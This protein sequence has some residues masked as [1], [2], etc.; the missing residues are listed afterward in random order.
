MTEPVST[1]SLHMVKAGTA[2][3]PVAARVSG[4]DRV[5]TGAAKHE[6]W[7]ATGTDLIGAARAADL[8][9]SGTAADELE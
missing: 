5:T 4:I 7:T 3:D 6:I 2:P 8:I 1:V 9:P